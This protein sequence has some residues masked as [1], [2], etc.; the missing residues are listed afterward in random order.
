MTYIK[1]IQ[2]ITNYGI[3]RNFSGSAE[4]LQGEG[5]AVIG[6]IFLWIKEVD[7]THYREMCDLVTTQ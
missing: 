5:Q 2:K 6:A 1:G 3:F 4:N 7:S